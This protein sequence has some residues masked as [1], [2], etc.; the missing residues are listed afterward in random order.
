MDKLNHSDIPAVGS[1]LES[2]P[3]L[4]PNLV[5][6]NG[7][8]SNTAP[9]EFRIQRRMSGPVGICGALP[10]YP[11]F[12]LVVQTTL[13]GVLDPAAI[14]AFDKH[15]GIQESACTSEDDETA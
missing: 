4:A 7:I 13:H 3:L 11:L 12:F 14:H 2:S 5:S 6:H 1:R 9:T 8:A 15:V 10:R